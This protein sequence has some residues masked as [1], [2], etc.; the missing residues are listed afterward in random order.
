MSRKPAQYE[1][2]GIFE[3]RRERP[4]LVGSATQKVY[5]SGSPEHPTSEGVAPG[6]QTLR[7]IS[8]SQYPRKQDAES[9]TNEYQTRKDRFQFNQT[10][11]T[12]HPKMLSHDQ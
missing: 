3:C 6:H 2:R 5:K 7:T 1:S 9:A 8:S 12:C 11:A 10:H 4:E